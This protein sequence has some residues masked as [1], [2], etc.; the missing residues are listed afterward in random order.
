VKKQRERDLVSDRKRILEKEIWSRTGE[1]AEIER[2]GL[3][4]VEKQR[5]RDLV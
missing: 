4:Q 1:E 2:S 5:E 3:G